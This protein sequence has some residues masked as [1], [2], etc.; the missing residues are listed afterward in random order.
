MIRE[1]SFGCSTA[2]AGRPLISL[3]EPG[4]KLSVELRI[5]SQSD[6]IGKRAWPQLLVLNDAWTLDWM[7]DKKTDLKPVFQDAYAAHVVPGNEIDAGPHSVDPQRAEF[8]QLAAEVPEQ[9][10]EPRILP[11]EMRIHGDGAA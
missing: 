1:G 8:P 11:F 4:Q 10:P 9:F 3:F 6:G 5:V 2:R 7:A